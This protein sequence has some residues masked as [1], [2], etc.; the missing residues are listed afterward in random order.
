MFLLRFSW[1]LQLSAIWIL[2]LQVRAHKN[3]QGYSGRV[4]DINGKLYALSTVLNVQQEPKN[5]I[6]L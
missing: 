3:P 1:C 4:E 5:K 6:L 2:Y